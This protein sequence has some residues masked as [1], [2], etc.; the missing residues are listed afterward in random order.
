LAFSGLNIEGRL[1]MTSLI[2]GIFYLLLKK[3]D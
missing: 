2:V 1:M 3:C